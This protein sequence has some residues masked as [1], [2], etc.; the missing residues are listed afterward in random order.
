MT[1]ALFSVVLGA[2]WPPFSHAVEIERKKIKRSVSVPLQAALTHRRPLLSEDRQQSLRARSFLAVDNS[3]VHAIDYLGEVLVG[4]P[5]RRFTAIFDTGSGSLLVPS[6]RCLSDACLKH[7]RYNASES[8]TSLQV[9]WLDNATIAP[10]DSTTRDTLHVTFG[11]GDADGQL[12]RDQVCLGEICGMANFVE[13]VW[14][15]E[16][17]FARS[18]WDAVLGLAPG[19]SPAPEYNVWQ[20]LSAGAAAADLSRPGL[21]SV[22]LG[23]DIEDGAEITFGDYLLHR[24]ASP[25]VW[26]NVSKMGYWQFSLADLVVNGSRLNLGCSCDGCCQAVVDSGASVMMGPPF[27]VNLMRTTIKYST[28]DCTNLKFP[29]IG[30][31]VKSADGHEHVLE[32][33]EEDYLDRDADNGTDWCFLHLMPM[34][35]TGRGPIFLLGMPFIRKFY[36]AFDLHGPKLGFALA[37]QPHPHTGSSNHAAWNGPISGVSMHNNR[38]ART[39]NVSKHVDSVAHAI[40]G[41]RTGHTTSTSL[42]RHLISRS[43][44]PLLACRFECENASIA[45][46]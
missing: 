7:R 11:S 29:S 15:A 22:W 31:V 12:A 23:R 42:K 36:T 20:V 6:S 4:T 38:V 32:M 17:P 26:V 37:K 1:W 24:Q 44:V 3:I 30:F 9:A 13:A 21:F 33:Q 25:P 5:P 41:N 10:E 34:K 40:L 16:K 27:V 39:E 8:R 2:T 18:R 28:D 46:P 19:I 45:L 35:D 43:A 14:E